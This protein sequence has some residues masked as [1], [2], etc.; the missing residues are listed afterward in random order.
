MANINNRIG[1]QNIVRVLSNSSTINPKLINLVDVDD[2]LK[3]QDKMVLVWDLPSQTF[4][5]TSITTSFE[6]IDGGDY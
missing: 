5:M 3:T 4:I 6:S 2:T 1:S